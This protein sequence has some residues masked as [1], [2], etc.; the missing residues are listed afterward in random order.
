MLSNFYYTI[1]IPMV[2]SNY[3]LISKNGTY[4][5]CDPIFITVAL[6]SHTTN[7][8]FVFYSKRLYIEQRIHYIH[9]VLREMHVLFVM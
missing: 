7:K 5:T 8:P 4:K 1:R 9:H 3:R 6:L 2:A